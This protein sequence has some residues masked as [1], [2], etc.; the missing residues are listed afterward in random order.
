MP[1]TAPMSLTDDEVYALTAY[2]LSINGIID[3]DMVIDA[4]S[5]PSVKMPNAGNFIWAWED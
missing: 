3:D 1:F 2:L 4:Q 5:L